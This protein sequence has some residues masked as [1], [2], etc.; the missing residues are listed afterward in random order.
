MDLHK[1]LKPYEYNIHYYHAEGAKVLFDFL[2]EYCAAHPWLHAYYV[3]VDDSDPEH[4]FHY[5]VT[6]WSDGTRPTTN[7]FNFIKT[8][9]KKDTT[10][11][12]VER[13]G[14]EDTWNWTMGEPF[15]D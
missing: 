14:Y 12:K 1:I 6:Y 8:K 4:Y 7:I 3:L 13:K 5:V 2:E 10:Q 15:N 11:L 9:E